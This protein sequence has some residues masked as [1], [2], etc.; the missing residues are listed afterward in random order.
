MGLEPTVPPLPRRFSK[1]PF[2]AVSDSV[3]DLDRAIPLYETTLAQRQ[4]V[5]GH[6]HPSTLISRNNL[7]SAR[8]ETEPVQHGSTATSAPEAAPQKPSTAD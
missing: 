7:A 6:T 1:C 5:L 4:Q 2:A 8:R 3:G